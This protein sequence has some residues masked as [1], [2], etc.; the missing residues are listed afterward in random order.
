MVGLPFRIALP[1]NMVEMELGVYT[2]RVNSVEAAFEWDAQP[3]EVAEEPAGSGAAP[4]AFT[5]QDGNV[6]V[7]EAPGVEPRQVTQDA[8]SGEPGVE[9]PSETVMYYFL[10][11]SSD[12]QMLA[13]RRDAGTPVESGMSYESGLWV[14]DLATGESR[15]VLDRTPAMFAW[16]P[17]THLLVYGLGVQEGY[18]TTRGE[19]DPD[20]AQGIWGV[21]LDQ[22]AAEPIEL[23]RPERGYS[24]ALPEWSP[25]GRFLSFDEVHLYEG[26]GLF[27]YYDFESEEYVSWD[28]AIGGYS[29]S[30]DGTQIVYDRLTY[31]ATGEERI[32]L[33][34]RAGGEERQLSPDFEQGYSFSPV[35]SPQGDRIAYL[36]APGGPDSQSYTLIVQALAG[37]E[38]QELGTFEGA[39]SLDWT[40]DGG[41]LVFGAGPYEEQQVHLVN[42]SD[43]SVTILSQ[44]RDPV[45][46][47]P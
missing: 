44:G 7:L 17:G 25:D 1:L 20:L 9:Q 22:E 15:Q 2:V 5:G 24:L 39:W 19:V 29:W 27:A 46:P 36:A 38:P 30:P 8:V 26:R 35:F 40:P 43:G 31:A 10:A 47:T 4:V 33:R 21:D 11:L 12:G 3:G 6:W 16:K 32:F 28:D 18:F 37:G 34:E 13:Y 14:A 41:S 45:L 42:A 23:V